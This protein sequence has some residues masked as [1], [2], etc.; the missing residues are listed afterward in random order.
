ME[1]MGF[2][3]LALHQDEVA[4][5]I[6]RSLEVDWRALDAPLPSIAGEISGPGVCDIC[7][8]ACLFCCDAQATRMKPAINDCFGRVCQF[9]NNANAL[10]LIFADVDKTECGAHP[11]DTSA[12]PA[13]FG[14]HGGGGRER[15][16]MDGG[17]VRPVTPAA[18]PEPL[19]AGSGG[20]SGVAPTTT[21][22]GEAGTC[23]SY[24]AWMAWKHMLSVF[25][26][27]GR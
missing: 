18:A 11:Q 21:L 10:L 20:V 8:L 9:F 13:S 6:A 12:P 1:V 26:P 14:R 7:S 4:L 17:V 27:G 23:G 24:I 2:D 25:V 19:T 5:Q 15:V 16:A 22:G 3:C